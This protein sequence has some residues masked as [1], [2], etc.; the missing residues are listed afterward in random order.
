[1]VKEDKMGGACGKSG[2][3]QNCLQGLGRNHEEKRAFAKGRHTWE[4]NIKNV[5]SKHIEEV[6][7]IQERDN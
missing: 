5:G 2:K 1:L 6:H 3:E 4:Y 7:L